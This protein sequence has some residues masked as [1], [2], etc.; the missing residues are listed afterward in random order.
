MK[1]SSKFDL[2]PKNS[3]I[4]KRSK[5][6]TRERSSFGNKRFGAASTTSARKF[7]S[8]PF[9]KRRE[10]ISLVED[11][12]DP[13]QRNKQTESVNKPSTSVNVKPFSSSKLNIL[14]SRTRKFGKKDE[15]ENKPDEDF[16]ASEAIVESVTE[17]SLMPSSTSRFRRP[18][19][20]PKFNVRSTP[21]RNIPS[22][23]SS[24]P[25]S[26]RYQP[27]SSSIAPLRRSRPTLK[28]LN[29]RSKQ[30]SIRRERTEDIRPSIT[31]QTETSSTKRRFYFDNNIFLDEKIRTEIPI[32]GRQGN[33]YKPAYDN[34]DNEL[35]VEPPKALPLPV[36]GRSRGTKRP[37]KFDP[38]TIRSSSTT[39][40]TYITGESSVMYDEI[41]DLEMTSSLTGPITVTDVFTTT[42][43]L[44]VHLGLR[45]SFATITTTAYSTNTLRREDLTTLTIAST[46]IESTSLV[47]MKV[48][49]GTRTDTVVNKR[50]MTTLTT[51]TNTIFEQRSAVPQLPQMH[52]MPQM[53]PNAP[54]APNSA[55]I[56]IFSK[57]LC[58]TNA[59][60]KY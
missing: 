55:T 1:H 7:G 2:N 30:K 49:Y 34:E 20:L 35:T 46:E 31:E 11:L 39:P 16:E 22:K 37:P 27:K 54:N 28:T 56:P 19:K 60:T 3:I 24:Q 40:I 44:P 51:Q 13:N 41:D 38:R 58:P 45:T 42:K 29:L 25:L 53:P 43:T 36:F 5:R 33:A 4:L 21:S 17:E 32:R 14:P 23:S 18:A 47:A 48:G 52:Q 8:T 26:S 15:E 12:V 10:E 9:S 57:S 6:S 50:I 59:F